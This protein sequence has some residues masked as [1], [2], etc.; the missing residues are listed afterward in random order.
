MLRRYCLKWQLES[1]D[2]AES[3]R[4]RIMQA[5]DLWGVRDC[6]V[7]IPALE[8]GGFLQVPEEPAAGTRKD[9]RFGRVSATLALSDDAHRRLAGELRQRPDVRL[10]ADPLLAVFDASPMPF[11]SGSV[12]GNR[13][14]AHRLIGADDLPPSARGRGVNVAIIDEGFDSRTLGHASFGGGWWR[15]SPG[16]G[17]AESRWIEPG[18]GRSAHARM[19]A[20]NVLALAPE[21]TIWDVPLLPDTSQGPPAVALAEAVFYYLWRDLRDGIRRAPFPYGVPPTARGA[22][23]RP[24]PKGALKAQDLPAGPWVLVNAWGV[25]DPS[26]YDPRKQYVTNPR[27]RFVVDMPRFGKLKDRPVDLVFAAGNCGEPT[28]VPRC[29]EGWTGPA[30]SIVGVNAHPDVLTV[31]SVRADGVANGMSAQGPG[32]LAARWPQ[33]D[34]DERK[35]RAAEKPDLCAPSGFHENDDT[36]L[37]NTGTSAAAGVMGGVVAALRSHALHADL[38]QPDPGTLR[39]LLRECAR[40]VPGQATP[41]DPRLGHGIVDVLAAL[42]SIDPTFKPPTSGD[43]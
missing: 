29:G 12:F 27:N 17:E 33:T 40:P 9:N 20:R 26:Q 36:A 2:R 35:R 6:L 14:L 8:A 21:A 3:V 19:V 30:R 4:S 22:R 37:L 25:L 10:T 43:R 41:W 38:P 28:P 11:A 7:G 23:S 13:K 15:Y 34:P 16:A 5:L 32:A 42:R 24:V 39:A 1:G 18:G 31:G